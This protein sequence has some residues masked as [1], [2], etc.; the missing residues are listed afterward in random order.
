MQGLADGLSVYAPSA[1]AQRIGCL[2]NIGDSILFYGQEGQGGGVRMAEGEDML[3]AE[4]LGFFISI[5]GERY[6][7]SCKS[8]EGGTQMPMMDAGTPAVKGH[9]LFCM[10]HKMAF[11]Q[12][13]PKSG[14]R[15]HRHLDGYCCDDGHFRFADGSI[16]EK[17][18]ERPRYGYRMRNDNT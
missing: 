7:P 3:C 11:D 2:C 14:I 12:Q 8:T 9:K 17:A 18:Q 13:S 16:P 1:S 5:D 15:F 6:C 10:E 4:C